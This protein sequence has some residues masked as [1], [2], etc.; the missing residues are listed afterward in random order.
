MRVMS[1][2]YKHCLQRERERESAHAWGQGHVYT[3][4]HK[5]LV[6]LTHTHTNDFSLVQG[7]LVH[8]VKGQGQ[9]VQVRLAPDMP[10]S[11]RQN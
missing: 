5:L 8:L 1:V 4:I 10:S 9:V 6:S 7:E 11:H 2:I 3:Q